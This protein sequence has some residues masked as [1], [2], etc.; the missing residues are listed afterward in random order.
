[1][2]T[3]GV[4]DVKKLN[5]ITSLEAHIHQLPFDFDKVKSKDG[6]YYRTPKN[7]GF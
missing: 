4:I 5:I 7:V 6:T 1:M 3:N 2:K